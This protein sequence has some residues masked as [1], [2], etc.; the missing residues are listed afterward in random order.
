VVVVRVVASGGCGGYV[1]C[2]VGFGVLVINCG[3][4]VGQ[5]CCCG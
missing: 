5:L 2:Y 3:G 4:R 1:V